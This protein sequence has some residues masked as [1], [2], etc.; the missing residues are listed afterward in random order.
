[1]GRPSL[2]EDLLIEAVE[3]Y[4]QYGTYHKASAALGIQQVTLQSRVKKAINRGYSPKHGMDQITPEGFSVIG[5]STLYDKS[6]GDAKIQWVKTTRDREQREL[7]MQAAVLAMS[8]DI[9][10]VEPIVSPTKT[11]SDLLTLYPVGDHHMGMLAWGEETGGANYDTKISEE[12]LCSAMDYLVDTAPCSEQA[13]ILVLGDFLHFEGHKPVT[14]HSGN[15]LDADSRYQA[16]VRAG[17]R[18]IKYIVRAALEKHKEVRL[19]LETGNHDRGPMA[20]FMEMFYMYYENEPRVI[21]DR[22]PRNIHI[23]KFGKNLVATHHGD[24]IKMDKL[25]LVIATDWPKMWGDTQYRTVHT[26]HVH[27]DHIKEHPGITTESHGIL[28]PKDEYAAS[29]GWRAKQSMKSIVLH[30][31]YGEVG[32]NMVT[33]NMLK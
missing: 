10:R 22:T 33:P 12:L 24:K 6:T 17:L 15:V 5:T 27:H 16:V 30:T 7:A 31:E 1:M 3:A 4:A 14:S 29:G 26:G 9:P 23:F 21:P 2:S 18:S 28:A 8:D 13:A 32:R 11:N 20:A 25:P 19:I